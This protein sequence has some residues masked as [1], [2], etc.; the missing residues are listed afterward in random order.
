MEHASGKPG[1]TQGA[2]LVGRHDARIVVIHL[3]AIQPRGKHRLGFSVDRQLSLLW[4]GRH[5]SQGRR[6]QV[7]EDRQEADQGQDQ[8]LTHRGLHLEGEVFSWEERLDEPYYP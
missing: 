3:L 5:G 2:R 6:D 8:A 1:I 7:R 4:G